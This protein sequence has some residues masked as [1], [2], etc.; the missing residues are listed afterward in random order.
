MFREWSWDLME[1]IEIH[2]AGYLL[3]SPRNPGEMIQFAGWNHQLGT[4]Q[5]PKRKIFDPPGCLIQHDCLWSVF[6]PCRFLDLSTFI[7]RLFWTC[8]FGTQLERFQG[9]TSHWSSWRRYNMMIGIQ[10]KK[11]HMEPQKIDGLYDFVGV[12]PFPS[13]LFLGSH[14]S[15]PGCQCFYIQCKLTFVNLG[16]YT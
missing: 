1:N 3:C 14:V 9:K 16:H 6:P 11:F 5:L 8:G 15:F 13:G 12:F 4:G 7:P 2:P 10:P